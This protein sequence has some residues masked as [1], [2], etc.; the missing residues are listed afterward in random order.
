MV[1]IHEP[2]QTR[3]EKRCPGGVSVSCLAS[4]QSCSIIVQLFNYCSSRTFTKHKALYSVIWV[5]KV[6]IYRESFL[7]S[8]WWYP[9][10][11]SSLL[12]FFAPFR[13]TVSSSM[14]GIICL[15]LQIAFIIFP[16]ANTQS[17]LFRIPFRSGDYW[18][19]PLRR[20]PFD[21]LYDILVN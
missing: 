13:S 17:D 10:R 5:L 14:V 7:S 9:H 15:S 8:N 4:R 3:G 1:D 19:Y 21:F 2:L 20:F 6:V 11:K 12:N 16:R 18:I